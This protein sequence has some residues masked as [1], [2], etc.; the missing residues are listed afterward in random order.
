MAE[1]LLDALASVTPSNSKIVRRSK[2]IFARASH[3]GAAILFTIS[4]GAGCM[5]TVPFH[6]A[7]DFVAGKKSVAAPPREVDPLQVVLL[8]AIAIAMIVVPNLLTF[9][10]VRAI[11]KHWYDW[12]FVGL[13]PVS[14]LFITGLTYVMGVAV[15]ILIMAGV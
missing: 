1:V 14:T 5:I 13:G 9:L 15:F 2:L 8:G 7:Y 4:F 6:A 3:I 10:F 11:W 12:D